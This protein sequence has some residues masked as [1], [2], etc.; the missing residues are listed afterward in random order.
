MYV[1]A[2]GA[3]KVPVPRSNAFPMFSFIRPNWMN[4]HGL[5]LSVK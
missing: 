2:T 3:V 5:A 4:G 1:P